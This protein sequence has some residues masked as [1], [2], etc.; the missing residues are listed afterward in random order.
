MDM[1]GHHQVISQVKS[2]RVDPP[3]QKFKR[4]GKVGA[5]VGDGPAV[6]KINSH[7]VTPASTSGALPIISRQWGDISHEHS[8]KHADIHPEL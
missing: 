3:C 5:V 2:R 4:I 6:S 7:T 8:V 1:F